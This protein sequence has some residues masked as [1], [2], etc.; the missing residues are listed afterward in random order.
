M[1]QIDSTVALW[2]L[3]FLIAGGVMVL[4]GSIGLAL[5]CLLLVGVGL[6]LSGN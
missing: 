3:C 1:G 2:C 5:A 6:K 4:K